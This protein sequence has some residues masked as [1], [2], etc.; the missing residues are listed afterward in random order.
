M[1][2]RTAILPLAIL[3]IGACEEAAP[4]PHDARTPV[5]RP[6]TSERTPPVAPLPPR[7]KPFG[8]SRWDWCARIEN[9]PVPRPD[10]APSKAECDARMARLMAEGRA[11]VL[12]DTR[13]LRD[14]ATLEPFEDR[15]DPDLGRGSWRQALVPTRP[16][17]C[18]FTER[19]RSARPADLLVLAS[20]GNMDLLGRGNLLAHDHAIGFV[21]A[22]WNADRPVI[23][24]RQ[25]LADMWIMP[26]GDWTKVTLIIGADRFYCH[27]FSGEAPSGQDRLR[28]PARSG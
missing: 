12:A 4:P 28:L 14:P 1:R 5:S 15:I 24:A 8:N 13:D 19:P 22:N 23:A 10:D 20:S 2:I 11:A 16:G 21:E 9:P 18:T 25:G 7:A 17:G 26:T 27:R 6:A 3:A